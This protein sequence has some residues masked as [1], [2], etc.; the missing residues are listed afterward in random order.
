MH[1]WSSI[2]FSIWLDLEERWTKGWA[3]SSHKNWAKLVAGRYL[4]NSPCGCLHCLIMCLRYYT[5][6]IKRWKLNEQ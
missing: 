5:W 3:N 6:A 2:Y 1:R 4:D